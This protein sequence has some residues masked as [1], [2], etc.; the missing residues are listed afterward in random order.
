M[1]ELNIKKKNID[2]F[3]LVAVGIALV[4]VAFNSYTLYGLS[5]SPG[6]GSGL[7]TGGST[8]SI[9]PTGSPKLYGSELD[10]SFDG[11]SAADPY[12]ADLTIGKLAD[13]DKT[14]TLTETQKER[15]INV[16]FTKEGGTSCEYCCG[17]KSVIFET[18]ESACGCAHS[19]AMRGLAKYLITEHGDEYTDDE[20]L[21]EVAK[22]KVLFFPTQMAQKAQILEDQGIDTSY[23]NVASNKYRGIEKGVTG[24][25]MVGGC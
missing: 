8:D 20:I 11:V 23:I 24:G 9:I 15:Y 6:G 16:L 14:I 10:V 4:L 22:W 13:L 7:V 19:Y 5:G 21:E 25:G 1:E 18:G 3:L 17:A 12:T 2:S